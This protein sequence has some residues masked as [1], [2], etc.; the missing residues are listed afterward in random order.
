[1]TPLKDLKIQEKRLE[2]K[3]GRM[4]F[5]LAELDDGHAVIT[6]NPEIRAHKD[7]KERLNTV[8]HEALHLGE[9][10]SRSVVK[11]R[12]RRDLTEGEVDCIA[13]T[14]AE[15]LWKAGYRRIKE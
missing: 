14:I 10:I 15:A 7:E 11:C 2:Y 4:F 13:G 6:I 9:W 12:E 3:D 5:G 1:M 8:C